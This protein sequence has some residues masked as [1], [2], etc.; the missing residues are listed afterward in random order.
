[1]IRRGLVVLSWVIAAIALGL[2]T[3]NAAQLAIA[4]SGP[5]VYSQVRCGTGPVGVT[6]SGTPSGGSYTAVS[7]SS[8]PS[9]CNGL[10]LQVALVNSSGTLLASGSGT[11]A[12]GTMTL[13]TGSYT[14]TAVS[15]VEVLIGTWAVPAT[16]TGPTTV[17]P[18]SCVAI[19]PSG[20]PTGQSCTVTLSSSTWWWGQWQVPG[21]RIGN[22]TYSV[23]TG[24]GNAEVTLDLS[25]TPY[26]GWSIVGLRTNG[27]YFAAPGYSCSQLP[28]VKL[29]PN[30][31]W[32]SPG[33]LYIEYVENLSDLGASN[34]ICP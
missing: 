12:T 16:W 25:Q 10:P 3:A 1:M 13:S 23:T 4:G 27:G 30:L 6:Y 9:S 7:I 17:P 5:A 20:N 11:A 21:T 18:M 29:R 26:T 28:I 24:A 2:A 19:N 14:G 15:S 34:R 33:P 8:I 32:G 31:A 22:A